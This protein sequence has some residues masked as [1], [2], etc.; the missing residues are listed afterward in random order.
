[1]T[2]LSVPIP[3]I[4]VRSLCKNFNEHNV[5]ALVDVTLTINRGE[6]VALTGPSGCG[7]STLLNVIAGIDK[8]S[9]GSVLLG[10]EE[11]SAFDDARITRLRRDKIGFVFQFFNLLSTLTV[12]EN[13]SLP[14]ALAQKLSTREIRTRTEEMLEQ[15]GLLKRID[16]YPSQLSGGEMQRVAIARALIHKPEVIVADEPTGNL[17]S[18]NGEQVLRLF[19]SLCREGNHTTL[20]ATHSADASSFADRTI[21]MRDGHVLEEVFQ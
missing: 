19:Q 17:D 11:I 9:S 7:K 16:F 18:E 15:V 14:L 12:F 6:F 21:K 8:P 3:H 2:D 10:E 20:M 4:Q 13:A 5:R 1:M